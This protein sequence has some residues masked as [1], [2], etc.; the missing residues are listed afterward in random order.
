MSPVRLLVVTW[1]AACTAPAAVETKPAPDDTAAPDTRPTE[2]GE[3]DS[4]ETGAPPDDSGETGDSSR[5]PDDTGDTGDDPVPVPAPC[6]EW[7]MPVTTGALADEDLNEVSGVA[8]SVLNP[9]VLWVHEDH[10]GPTVLTAVDELGNT[11]GTLTLEG[12]ENGD[13]EAM[14]LAPC[15][16]GQCLWIADMGDNASERD[17]LSLLRVPEPIVVEGLDETATPDV[18]PVTYGDGFRHNVE[19]F[20]LLPDGRAVVVTKRFDHTAAVFVLPVGSDVFEGVA[21][22]TTGE[23]EDD[24]AADAVTS[25]DLWPDGTRM[26]LRT[27]GVVTEID[28]TDAGLDGIADAPRKTLPYAPVVHTE[29]VAY[30]AERRGYWQIPEGIGAPIDF[31]GCLD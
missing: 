16:W 21:V 31:V 11:L 28:L 3:P 9:G 14:A 30:D 23:T 26:L 8:P 22:M 13:W 24:D 6:E 5:G 1:I 10:G 15:E 27:Y 7:G 12:V 18:F 17:D 2:T 20:A 4:G 19:A 25:A 29:A